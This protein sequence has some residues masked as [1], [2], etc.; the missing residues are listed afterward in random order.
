MGLQ[1]CAFRG[2]Y[3]KTREGLRRVRRRDEEAPQRRLRA[4]EPTQ[5]PKIKY[6]DINEAPNVIPRDG[7]DVCRTK[8]RTAP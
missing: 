1:K 3:L 8:I 6:F 4:K 5:N 7:G 2:G